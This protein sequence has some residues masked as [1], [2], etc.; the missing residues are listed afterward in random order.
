M[1]TSDI[2]F[3][4]V[5]SFL[6]YL[7][8]MFLWFVACYEDDKVNDKNIAIALLWP[9]FFIKFILYHTIVGFSRAIIQLLIDWNF[10]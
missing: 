3:M 6:I 7:L 10:K 8:G 1:T 9:L 5:I 4:Y 2:H